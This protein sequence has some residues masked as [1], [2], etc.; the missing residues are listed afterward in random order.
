MLF[1]L[2]TFRSTKQFLSRN[3]PNLHPLFSYSSVYGE[4]KTL[5]ALIYF[6]YLLLQ[7]I[8]ELHN[9]LEEVAIDAVY[10]RGQICFSFHHQQSHVLCSSVS[11]AFSWVSGAGC[12]G[13]SM[14]VRQ[15][16]SLNRKF[17]PGMV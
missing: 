6:P 17:H 4:V 5:K 1:T 7:G 11:S 13:S 14:A 3:N 12:H 16:F 8:N 2:V 9:N 15:A 10:T